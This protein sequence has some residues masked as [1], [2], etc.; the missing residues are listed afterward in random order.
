MVG[1]ALSPCH[2]PHLF[3]KVKSEPDEQRAFARQF[4]VKSERVQPVVLVRH[5]QQAHGNLRAALQETTAR[6]QVELPEVITRL[7]R[8]V[9]IVVLR[10]PKRLRLRE[11]S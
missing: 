2:Y 11:E 1:Q 3:S 6:E 10:R 7:I 9:A 5:V 8:P 4:G